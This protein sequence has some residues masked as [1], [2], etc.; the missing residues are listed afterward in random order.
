MRSPRDLAARAYVALRRARAV[1]RY[2]RGGL[3][4]SDFAY[5]RRFAA[6]EG[7]FLDV[8]ANLGMSALSIRTVLP[9][10]RILSVEPNPLH[11]PDLRHVAE[12]V[13]NMETRYL[14]AHERPGEMELHVPTWRGLPITGEASLSREAI[15]ESDQLRRRLGE[16]MRSDRFAIRS[17][18]VPIVPLD[19]LEL[20]PRWV[21]IDVQGVADAVL[22]GLQRT[23]ERHR[24]TVMVESDGH[25]N[26]AVIGHLGTLG[27]G[28]FVYD[29]AADALVP[30]ADQG[31]QNI[32][33]VPD[34]P[35]VA[36]H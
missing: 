22:R 5:F 17:F 24:P 10:A 18:R 27:Y 36:G 31:P 4:E 3:H 35:A 29:A 1:A 30:F 12:R 33:F 2:K 6:E 28:A 7:L 9:R 25:T 26:A 13:G 11:E 20:A 23:L 32:F 15:L 16:R 14:A 21:K 8:G 19:E 34:G